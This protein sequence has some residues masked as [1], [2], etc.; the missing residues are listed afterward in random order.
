MNTDDESNACCNIREEPFQGHSYLSHGGISI[1]IGPFQYG[2]QKLCIGGTLRLST[3]ATS[4]LQ[5][6]FTQGTCLLVWSFEF[7]L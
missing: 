5:V 7:L 3:I 1:D 6:H 4:L 2:N